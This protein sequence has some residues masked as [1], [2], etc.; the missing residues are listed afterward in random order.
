MR[1]LVHL[2][3]LHFGRIDETVLAP[4]RTAVLAANPDLIAIS[5]D[6]T[7]RAKR[8]EFR[9]ARAFIDTL[10]RP[11]LVVPGNHDVPLWNVA[12]RFLAPFGRYRA[13][14]SEDLEPEYADDQMI[15]VGV[16]TARSFAHGEGRINGRQVDRIVERLAAVPGGLVRVI[17]THHPFD[18]PP[19]VRE[20]RLLG[21]ARMAMARLAKA[22]ADLFLSGHLHLSHA[23][24][25]VERYRIEGHSALIV[26]AGT[27]SLRG[28]GEQPSFNLLRC[29][30]PDI[31]LVRY[32]WDPAVRE[33]VPAAVGRYRHTATGWIDAS[34]GRHETPDLKVG[35][36]PRARH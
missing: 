26:Q 8:K 9:A 10:D 6:F 24:H 3:D 17:M 18:L 23:S 13:F 34:P 4:L 31:E 28:R 36:T 33:F 25:S 22:N 11:R 16:N 32:A 19:G 12:R 7:Q 27:I 14:I 30:R 29:E 2:S 35:P 15:V 20:A 21:R 5:G 1:T